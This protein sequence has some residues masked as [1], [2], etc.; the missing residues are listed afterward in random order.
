MNAIKVPISLRKNLL[1]GY[2][3]QGL[4]HAGFERTYMALSRSYFWEGM[5]KDI[6]MFTKGCKDCQAS[7]T[8]ALNKALLKPLQ[9]VEGFAR[10]L[11][12]DFVGPILL[13][14]DGYRYIFSVV[15]SFTTWTWLFPTKDMT[16]ETAIDCLI[17]VVK[18]VG[19]FTT[20][21]SDQ[22]QALTGKIRKGFCNQFDIKKIRT[23]P[24]F[25]RSNSRVERMHSTLGNALRTTCEDNKEWKNQLPF[26][27]M[28]LRASPIR[29]LG[30]SPFEMV[31]GGKK[32]LLPVDTQILERQT[33]EPEE[34]GEY[35]LELRRNL[36]IIEKITTR[37]IKFNQ[38]EF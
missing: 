25:P 12:I 30:L 1:Q 31:H 37:N 23:S 4:C 22:A 2:H 19:C 6:K 38:E 14:D 11:H 24:Y 33:E 3:N 16:A 15:D 26:I 28:A 20:L 36:D 5:W 18:E 7:K 29:G 27:E 17:Q 32:M 21:V 13:T 34:I 9:V 10:K 8:Y 35:L